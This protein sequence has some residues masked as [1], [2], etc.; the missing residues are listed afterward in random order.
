MNTSF[1]HLRQKSTQ[2]W[3]QILNH[4]YVRESKINFKNFFMLTLTDNGLVICF[5]KTIFSIIFVNH[6][7]RPTQN[8]SQILTHIY[9]RGLKNLSK[10]CPYLYNFLKF[11]SQLK[12]ILQLT[13]TESSVLVGCIQF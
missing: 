7:Q 6:G 2:N 12:K 5:C 10:K 13:I 4:I 8:W 9:G 1:G 11:S 3:S